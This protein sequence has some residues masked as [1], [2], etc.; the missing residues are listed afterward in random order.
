MD[1]LENNINDLIGKLSQEK[2]EISSN[3]SLSYVIIKFGDI[4]PEP[5]HFDKTNAIFEEGME[6]VLGTQLGIYLSLMISK[7]RQGDH[8]V[9]FHGP[10]PWDQ[11]PDHNLLAFSFL[12]YDKYIKDPRAI[13]HGVITIVAIFYHSSDQELIKAKI[14]I[15]NELQKLLLKDPLPDVTYEQLPLLLS[16]VK[17]KINKCIVEGDR[18]I[19]E[20]AMDSL[21]SNDRLLYVGL[22]Q[23]NNR[24]LI[25]ALIG[26]EEEFIDIISETKMFHFDIFFTKFKEIRFGLINLHKYDKIAIVIIANDDSD[27]NQYVFME[28][29]FLQLYQAIFVAAPLLEEYYG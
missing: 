3:D 16:Q 25:T 7:G 21:L 26:E 27:A 23:A 12:G 20:N 28:N 13:E 1:N 19:Q 24:E 29:D 5:V 22:Y 11:T 2:E 15:E 10:Y 9:G 17:A 4:G 18:I 8:K 14:S 6:D